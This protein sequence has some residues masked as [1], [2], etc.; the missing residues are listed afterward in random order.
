[1]IKF[2]M[3]LMLSVFLVMGGCYWVSPDQ[4]NRI[5][6]ETRRVG[7]NHLRMIGDKIEDF[8]DETS[9]QQWYEFWRWGKN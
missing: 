3:S 2:L 9:P 8:A 6:K 4:S 5:V 7:E 1:M